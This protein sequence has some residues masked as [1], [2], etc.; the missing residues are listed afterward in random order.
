[1][2]YEG[3][4]HLVVQSLS[5]FPFMMR[6]QTIPYQPE[7]AG[8]QLSHGGKKNLIEKH[9]GIFHAECPSLLSLP[10]QNLLVKLHLLRFTEK[11]VSKDY[12]RLRRDCTV[13]MTDCKQCKNRR[14][15]Q[16]F[17]QNCRPSLCLSVYAIK[18]CYKWLDQGGLN[19]RA[20]A[21]KQST[22]TAAR[23]TGTDWEKAKQYYDPMI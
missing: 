20:S 11:W 6:D 22:T 21:S 18:I 12:R 10:P 3:Q 4:L 16:I 23:E 14:W 8:E 5:R 9:N 17:F 13:K 2:L 15:K 7:L 19:G 1:M